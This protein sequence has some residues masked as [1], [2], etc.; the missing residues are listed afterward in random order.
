MARE[1]CR[2]A[3]MSCREPDLPTLAAAPGPYNPGQP[4]AHRL[5]C[6]KKLAT[7]KCA[8]FCTSKCSLSIY[9]AESVDLIARKVRNNMFT[10]PGTTTGSAFEV[11]RHLGH[12]TSFPYLSYTYSQIAALIYEERKIKMRR[13]PKI[14]RFVDSVSGVNYKA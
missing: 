6:A 13:N 2:T 7:Q 14:G 4:K 5:G 1:F 10:F 12:Q 8:E 9:L 3:R 11:E